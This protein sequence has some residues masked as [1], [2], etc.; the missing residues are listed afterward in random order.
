MSGGHLLHLN[1]DGG[2]GWVEWRFECTHS[3]DEFQTVCEVCA[4]GGDCGEDCGTQECWAQSWWDDIGFEEAA[5]GD[6]PA[7]IS[8][9]CPVVPRWDGGLAL[10]YDGKANDGCPR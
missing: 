10:H 4:D 8:F 9:P 3:P 6:W 7:E 5:A 1:I 2:P